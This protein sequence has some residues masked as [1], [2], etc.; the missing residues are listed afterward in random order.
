M[1]HQSDFEGA[2]SS[3]EGLPPTLAQPCASLEQALA[4]LS[5]WVAQQ[6]QSVAALTQLN[7][8]MDQSPDCVDITEAAVD[9]LIV[10]QL[11]QGYTPRRRIPASEEV[12]ARDYLRAMRD[13]PDRAE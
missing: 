12:G 8:M 6:Q 3:H 13:Q 1:H 10:E 5:A 9:R 7:T 4:V 2:A 11:M